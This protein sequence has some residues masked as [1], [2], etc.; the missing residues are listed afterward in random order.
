M[1]DFNDITSFLKEGADVAVKVKNAFETTQAER[2]PVTTIQMP[3]DSM[4]KYMPVILIGGAAVIVLALL[5]R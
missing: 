4:S 5:L 1:I 2:H 3:A